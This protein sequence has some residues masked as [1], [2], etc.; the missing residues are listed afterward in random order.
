[1]RGFIRT[2]DVLGNARL[3]VREFGLRC[4]LYSLWRA[5]STTGTVT[6]LECV[7]VACPVAVQPARK[8]SRYR[9]N[10]D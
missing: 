7:A 8:L 6:F 3:I 1:M 5:L 4:F 10:P 9:T 2:R